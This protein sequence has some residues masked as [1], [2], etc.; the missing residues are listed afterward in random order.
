[1]AALALALA[2]AFLCSST[3][4]VKMALTS[5]LPCLQIVIPQWSYD[6][7]FSSANQTQPMVAPGYVGANMSSCESFAADI[8]KHF[9]G[10]CFLNQPTF[11]ETRAVMLATESCAV[12]AAVL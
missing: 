10:V 6:T 12:T 7:L 8:G 9:C 1:M 11:D 5:C 3:L 2:L 4:N